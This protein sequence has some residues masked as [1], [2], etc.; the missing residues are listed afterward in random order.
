M[1]LKMGVTTLKSSVILR[2]NWPWPKV[3]GEIVLSLRHSWK[4]CSS[5]NLETALKTNQQHNWPQRTS[6]SGNGP[7]SFPCR[8]SCPRNASPDLCCLFQLLYVVNE[9]FYSMLMSCGEIKRDYW[10]LGRLDSIG[11]VRSNLLQHP[12]IP[13]INIC[14]HTEPQKFKGRSTGL[15]GVMNGQGDFLPIS[16]SVV[17][18]YFPL[19]FH[20]LP[21]QKVRKFLFQK[22]L[23]KD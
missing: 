18:L 11:N 2:K 17:Y 12:N 6:P 8:V 22:G 21:L 19:P 5:N 20:L 15:V 9:K 1:I 7:S 13:H 10:L 3:K 23:E 4:H 16:R 14:S